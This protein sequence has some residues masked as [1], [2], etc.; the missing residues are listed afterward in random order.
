MEI[1]SNISYIHTLNLLYIMSLLEQL[2]KK[3]KY[4]IIYNMC[5]IIEEIEK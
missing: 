3:I 4:Y 2:N 1:L 5:I